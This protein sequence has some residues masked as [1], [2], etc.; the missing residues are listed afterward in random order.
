MTQHPDIIIIGAGLSGLMCAKLL[1]EKGIP[2]VLFDKAD[3][4]GGR[5][6]T[7]I[8]DGFRLDR[9]FQ[10]LLT[11]Y[12]TAQ[13]YLNYQDL[14]LRYFYSGAWVH[15]GRTFQKVGDPRRH[16]EDFWPTFMANI[17]RLTDK[18]K[19]LKMRKA[20]LTEAPEAIFAKPNMPT[21][22]ALRQRWRFSESM[23]EMFFRPF[24]GGIL[25]DH[26]LRSSARMAEFVFKMFAT[27]FA[28]VPA[29][30]MQKIPEQL[31]KQ[32]PSDKIRLNTAVNSVSNGVVTLQT[33]EI[34]HPKWVVVATDGSEAGNLLSLP[35]SAKYRGVTT[36][37]FSADRDPIQKPVLILEGEPKG[38]VNHVVSMSAVA[39]MYAPEGKTLLSVTVLDHQNEKPQLLEAAVLKQMRL[40]FKDDLADWK[41]LKTY[42]IPLALPDQRAELPLSKAGYREVSPNVFL[43]G[44]HQVTG[45]I[46]GAIVSGINTA[47]TLI[48]K[49]EQ[50][51]I[52]LP[53]YKFA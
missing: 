34:L 1:D 4:V 46:E 24:F 8:V 35:K 28:A 45:S 44:D 7:D 49:W 38:P 12:P 17:G 11:A 40:W 13:K 47:Q 43:C 31:A 22:E 26:S 15:A 27:G 6:R 37:Y 18:V 29:G 50:T 30:G 42:Y 23:I 19:I 21:I 52:P 41:L 25:L 9:G 33:G 14:D 32:L 48:T 2:F 53:T 16:R 51:N 3:Q 39:P 20:L 36:L 10:V 5:I